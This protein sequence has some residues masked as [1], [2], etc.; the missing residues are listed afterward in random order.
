M[1]NFI[2][3]T[4]VNQG[5][6]KAFIPNPI[7]R[8]WEI[9]DMETVSLLSRADRLLGQLDMYSNYVNIDLYLS[10]HIAKEATQSSRIEGTQTNMEEVFMKREEIAKERRDDWEEL[11]NYIQ[12]MNEATANLQTLPFSSR[13]IRQTHKILLQG[14][15]GKHK[16]PGEFRTSQ[17]WIGGA[18][19]N[20]ARFIPP[21]HTEVPALISDLEK[22]AND[23]SNPLPEL[24]KIAVIHYQFETIHPFL[25]GNGRIGRL[26]ITL[27]LVNKGLLKRPILY[28][29]DF[30]ER[31]RDLYYDN[32][33]LVRTKNDMNQW[34]KFFLTGVIQTAEK[35]I[36][37]F[38]DIL[39]LQK[40]LAEKVNTLGSRAADANKVIEELYKNPVINAVK[41]GQII[42]KSNVSAY[43]LVADM[44]KIGILREITGG[45]R[46]RLYAFEDYLKLF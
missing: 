30:F 40:T 10:L 25:D 21:P 4:T 17:N 2:S 13:L 23:P 24:L 12:A 11:Q 27:Y 20:D 9:T 6:Y 46:G 1:K 26:L 14:V 3:G 44:E 32:L 18:S 34:F 15:R 36:K 37:T 41:I 22:F 28:L 7:N 43:K 29:S 38:D 19:I 35:G 33:T 31:H 8:N 39:Q 42:E 45:Q 5:Y 16:M